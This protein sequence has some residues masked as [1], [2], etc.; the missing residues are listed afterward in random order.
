MNERT[1]FIYFNE[2]LKRVDFLSEETKNNKE[3][4]RWAFQVVCTRAFEFDG[5]YRLTPMADMVR[6]YFS[7]LIV[8]DNILARL[9]SV[10]G[11]VFIFSK[12]SIILLNAFHNNNSLTMA[13]KQRWR[14]ATTK[15]AIVMPTPRRTFLRAHPCACRMAIRPTRLTFLPSTAFWTKPPRPHFV[16][17]C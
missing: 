13:L 2:A 11:F 8:V 14:S 15:K 5:E 6:P 12:L 4:A 7:H 1:K 3:L 9:T 10:L 17:L 16:K